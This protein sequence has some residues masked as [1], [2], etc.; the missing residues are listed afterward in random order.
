VMKEALFG[1]RF[2]DIWCFRKQTE[3]DTHHGVER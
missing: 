3:A 1:F 2:C